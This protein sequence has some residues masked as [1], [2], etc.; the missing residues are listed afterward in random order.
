MAVVAL[1]TIGVM[2][3]ILF[4]ILSYLGLF[5]KIKVQ[6]R[7]PPFAD[8]IFLYKFFRG[9]YSNSA[10]AFHEVSKFSSK[11]CCVGIYFDDPEKVAVDEC[12]YAVGIFIE[13]E[14]TDKK[15][16]DEIK[17]TMMGVGYRA[18]ETPAISKAMCASF[19][20]KIGLSIVFAVAKVYPALRSFVLEHKIAPHPYLEYHKGNRIYF[21][22]PLEESEKFYVPEYALAQTGEDEVLSD[23]VVSD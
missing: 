15:E 16:A 12:C 3:L 6:V 21:V 9:R 11:F 8:C 17:Q 18:M 20:H 2:A 10:P 22:A 13:K 7:R 5:Q 1:I 19:P 14:K 23:E 4:A